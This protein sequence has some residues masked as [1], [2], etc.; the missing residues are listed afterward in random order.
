MTWTHDQL[1]IW[2]ANKAKEIAKSRNRKD[3]PDGWS[4][5][6][7]LMRLKLKVLGMAFRRIE[8]GKGFGDCYKAY[9]EAK[10]NMREVTLTEEENVWLEENGVDGHL[11]DWHRWT[12]NLEIRELTKEIKHLNKL[13]SS[14]M[15]KELRSRHNDRMR[16]I[17][18]AADR[19]KI[20]RILRQI[21]GGDKD[22]FLEVLYNE[23]E[24][25][26]DGDEIATEVNK[27]FG[28]SWFFQTE[29]EKL[30]GIKLRGLMES[31]CGK[32][33]EEMSEEM[34]GGGK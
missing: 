10:R 15:R 13:T 9:K 19:G 17:Q 12:A 8:D 23:G 18:D 6:T 29:D 31:G 33:F 2:T 24:N 25:M 16:K 27:I 11:P 20:G 5:L 14:R 1:V 4:P 32:G 3:N 34:K 22:F 7:R 28:Q 30:K 26:I 21:I